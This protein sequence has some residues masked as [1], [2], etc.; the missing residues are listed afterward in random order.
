MTWN[1]LTSDEKQNNNTFIRQFQIVMAVNTVV[2]KKGLR[3]YG[4]KCVK[5]ITFKCALY[6]S[7]MAV[8][9]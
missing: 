4:Y 6:M 2:S 9:V 3:Y 7:L 8:N 5:Q 1:I